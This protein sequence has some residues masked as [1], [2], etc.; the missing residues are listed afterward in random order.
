MVI[1]PDAS[2]QHA[3]HCDVIKDAEISAAAWSIGGTLLSLAAV[4]V[5][6]AG[7]VIAMG[8]ILGALG[9]AG[10]G[11]VAGGLIGA[12]TEIR[13]SQAKAH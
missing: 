7:P 6:G 5:P 4:G 2:D 1:R 8:P 3:E 10:I 9:G 11:A 13:I 12:L